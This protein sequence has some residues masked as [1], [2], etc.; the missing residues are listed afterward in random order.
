VCIDYDEIQL[1]TRIGTWQRGVND[2]YVAYYER[3]LK[4]QAHQ[5]IASYLY[6]SYLSIIGDIR[7]LGLRVLKI[8]PL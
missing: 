7:A 2:Y 4:L 1:M 6:Y 5:G 3:Q 8:F